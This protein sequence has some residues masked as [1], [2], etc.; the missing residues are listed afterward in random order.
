MPMDL[1]L[2]LYL[3]F[4][5][6]VVADFITTRLL[7]Q[8]RGPSAELNP[9]MRQIATKSIYH[10][11]LAEII[12]CALAAIFLLLYYPVIISIGGIILLVLI[13][14]W[15]TVQVTNILVIKSG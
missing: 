1:N 10:H 9:L 4:C 13:S 6:V 7:I 2:I 8:R 5:A 15:G 14:S 11:A 12:V 3:V